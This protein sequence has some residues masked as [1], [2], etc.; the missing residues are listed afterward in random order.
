MKFIKN[1]KEKKFEILTLVIFISLLVLYLDYRKRAEGYYKGEFLRGANSYFICPGNYSKHPCYSDYGNR[2][3]GP[4]TKPDWTLKLANSDE[5]INYS[6]KKYSAKNCR[7]GSKL[8][9]LRYDNMI[10]FICLE[11]KE[12]KAEG[13]TGFFND[14]EDLGVN[15]EDNYFL[16]ASN[17]S[18]PILDDIKA[19]ADSNKSLPEGFLTPDERKELETVLKN[20]EEATIYLASYFCKKF[21]ENAYEDQNNLSKDYVVSESF[22]VLTEPLEGIIKEKMSCKSKLSCY[23]KYFFKDRR[24]I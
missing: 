6:G 5:K 1:L 22:V 14:N 8:V 4:H 17:Y 13:L 19:T 2:S 24:F 16:K 7:P 20:R 21:P 12:G 3:F 23:F 18:I 11:V 10:S 9:P 15:I